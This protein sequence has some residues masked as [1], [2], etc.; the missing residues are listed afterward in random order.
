MPPR[1]LPSF[2]CALIA[3]MFGTPL[4]AGGALAAANPLE[5]QENSFTFRGR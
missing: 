2:R 3:A 1:R 5:P 4:F